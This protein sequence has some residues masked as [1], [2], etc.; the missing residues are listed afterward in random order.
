[1]TLGR[2][3][4]G[5]RGELGGASLVAL[6]LAAFLLLAGLLAVDVGALV[7]AR[8]A[9]QTAADMAALAALT[10]SGGAPPA[11]AAAIASANGAELA[12]CDCSAVQAVVT[13]RRRVVLAPTG[14]SV[15]VTARARAV[16]ATGP[17]RAAEP[18]PR[19]GQDDQH[20]AP[21]STHGDEAVPQ[22]GSGPGGD[23]A[24]HL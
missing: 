23:V 4:V 13:V 3:P 21:G 2:A 1:V 22:P 5:G 11:R 9:A 12:G 20:D 19:V 14:L 10:P 16:L 15:R 8:A 7:A 18:S 24:G 6:A 17:P